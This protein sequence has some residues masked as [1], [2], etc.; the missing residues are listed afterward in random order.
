MDYENL[1]LIDEE[2][3]EADHVL[4][5]E[6]LAGE[7]W[8]KILTE[9][10][11][12]VIDWRQFPISEEL[13]RKNKRDT[14][15]CVSFSGN[16]WVQYPM[17]YLMSK[18]V[19]FASFLNKL[20]MLD[21]NGNPNGSD[22]RTA[23]GSGTNP[24]AGNTV[25][26][27]DD[28]IRDNYFCPEDMWPF[29]DDMTRDEYYG[30]MPADVADYGKKFKPLV[31]I[32]TKYLPTA[33]YNR[34]KLYST[35]DQIMD[36][37]QYSPVWVSV[38]VPYIREGEFIKAEE[39]MQKSLDAGTRPYGHRVLVVAGKR[40]EWFIVHDQYKNQFIKFQYGYRYGSCKIC[41]IKWNEPQY[42]DF[43]KVGSAILFLAKNGKYAGQYIG[44]EDGDVAKAVLENY[45]NASPKDTLEQFPSNYIGNNLSIQNSGNA[46][47]EKKNWIINLLSLI[48]KK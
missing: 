36:G 1:G 31:E 24:N 13:Q 45:S 16:K 20:K 8:D 28:Y 9:N 43:I 17:K 5:S 39:G 15:A 14:N 38:K 33:L 32:Q 19:S 10:K 2:P 22:R 6:N 37:L 3:R 29:P 30:V 46:G 21:K 4:G 40:N 42:K 41:R 26:A 23:K 11:E 35:P 7:V 18:S 12:G 47:L 44:Y 27:V 25:R 34:Y 48:F